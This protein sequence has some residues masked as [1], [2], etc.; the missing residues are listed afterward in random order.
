MALLGLVGLRVEKYIDEP[1]TTASIF[2]QVRNTFLRHWHPFYAGTALLPELE[3]KLVQYEAYYQAWQDYLVLY[4]R[5]DRK[6]GNFSVSPQYDN[7]RDKP[8]YLHMVF[9]AGRVAPHRNPKQLLEALLAEIQE[10]KRVAEFEAAKLELAKL[11]E[12]RAKK[13]AEGNLEF[14]EMLNR[15]QGI[16][17]D[18]EEEEQEEKEKEF[19]DALKVNPLLRYSASPNQDADE[20]MAE[21]NQKLSEDQARE[22]YERYRDEHNGSPLV[23]FQ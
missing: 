2:A 9:S 14:R 22:E 11:E 6:R 13:E 4:F 5:E 19:T 16:L 1:T 10:H 15:F 17:R 8:V 3:S 23:K 20:V 18:E 7:G 21:I 12:E